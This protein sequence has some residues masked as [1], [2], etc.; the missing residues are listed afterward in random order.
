[1]TVAAARALNRRLLWAGWLLLFVGLSFVLVTSSQFWMAQ[2]NDSDDYMRMARVRDL[3]NG[4]G[5]YDLSQPRLSPGDH[6]ILPW[7]R[8]V[9]IPLAAVTLLFTPLVGQMAASGVAAFL[10]PLLWL[11]AFA[12]VLPLA[13]RG[14]IPARRGWLLLFVMLCSFAL[15]RELRPMRV[16]HHGAQLFFALAAFVTLRLYQLRPAPRWRALTGIFCAC[17][18]AIGAESFLSLALCSGWIMLGAA[19]SNAPRRDALGFA[20][21]LLGTLLLALPLLR[22]PADWLVHDLALPALPHL[23]VS[24]LLAAILLLLHRLPSLT[25]WRGLAIAT[26]GGL[27]ALAML[28]L[29]LPELHAGLYGANMSADNQNLIL[30][31]VLEA[32]SYLQRFAGFDGTWLGVRRYWPLTAHN[33]L[34]PV[35]AALITLVQLARTNPWRHPERRQRWQLWLLQAW[36]LLP[37]TLLGLFWQSRVGVYMALQAL[38]PLGWLL[39]QAMQAW[40]RCVPY[41]LLRLPLQIMTLALLLVPTVWGGAWLQGAKPAQVVLFPSWYVRNPCNFKAI[42]DAL[43]DTKQFGSKP[44]NIMATMTGGAELLYRT[45]HRVF[46]APYDVSG[47][48]LALQFF[49]ARDLGGAYQLARMHH[50]DIVLMCDGYANYY[51]PDEAA[52]RAAGAAAHYSLRSEPIPP[53]I[54]ADRVLVDYLIQGDGPDWLQPIPLPFTD[55]HLYRVHLPPAP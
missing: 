22:P 33:L 54:A 39:A 47:N 2:F 17:G 14:L 4:Q 52:R 32:K 41:R 55:L 45:D 1:M 21:G 20:A 53:E 30:G 24:C 51:L 29:A 46:A 49:G 42:A 34:L 40:Q 10:V 43:N 8:L 6:F 44:L 25:R 3:L 36:F 11:L 27:S 48:A 28:W 13:G 23:L 50:I 35:L 12:L 7:S 5:W 15:L 16:D 38:V 26:F 37:V 31:T 9:D 18:L 19:W